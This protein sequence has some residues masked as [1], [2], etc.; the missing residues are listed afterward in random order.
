MANRV[1]I[2]PD[3]WHVEFV[4]E[5]DQTYESVKKT[6]DESLIVNDLLRSQGK[7]IRT[8]VDISKMGKTDYG[9]RRAGAEGLKEVTYDRLAVIAAKSSVQKSLANFV[10]GVTGKRENTKY[11]DSREEALKWLSQ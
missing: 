8:I 11:F 1:F 9:A 6:V 4:M 10:I 3:G 7:P 5:G 2:A